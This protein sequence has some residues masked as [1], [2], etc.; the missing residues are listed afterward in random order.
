MR[1]AIA[2][3]M[4][5]RPPRG[6][7]RRTPTIPA[8]ITLLTALLILGEPAG[9]VTSGEVT[10]SKQAGFTRLSFHFAEQIGVELSESNGIVI[11]KF[12]QPVQIAI[13]QLT[14]AAP[15]LIAAARS[16]PDGGAVRIALARK[17]KLHS[18]PAAEYFFLDFL[19]EN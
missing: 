3:F 2:R 17:V 15:D 14:A 18:I 7:V 5:R 9:A 4:Y 16:D 13:E 1:A 10:L 8:A 6:I 19:P 11:L 12:A